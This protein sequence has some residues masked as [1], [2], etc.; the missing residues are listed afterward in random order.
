MTVKYHTRNFHVSE[1][2]ADIIDKK[3]EKL[4]KYFEKGEAIAVCQ[5]VGNRERMELT[6]IS[7]G[8]SFRAQEESDSMYKNVDMVLAKIER[9]I[10]K[11]H[12]KLRTII[13]KEAVEQKKYE[14]I[15]PK[16]V[17]ST[18]PAEIKK[19]KSFDIKTLSDADAELN[20]ATLD[21]DFFVYA[22]EKTKGVKVMYKRDDGHVGVID[23]TNAG[24]DAKKKK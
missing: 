8:H 19:T 6:I 21:H 5:K 3:L 18:M 2:L 20:L 10:V 4:S 7:G 22:D 11:N 12:E 23:V 9:Q 16:H 17:G 14:Y 1:K 15:K 13:R 24:V